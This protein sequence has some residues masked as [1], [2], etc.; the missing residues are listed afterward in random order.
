M[1]TVFIDRKYISVIPIKNRGKPALRMDWFS[2][3]LH[4]SA[5][6]IREKT[7]IGC[8]IAYS[9]TKHMEKSKFHQLSHGEVVK[10]FILSKNFYG[11]KC[12][13]KWSFSVT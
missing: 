13:R 12:K 5:V 2:R 11:S 8:K 7:P 6:K 4:N 1:F 9:F 10:K 3:N